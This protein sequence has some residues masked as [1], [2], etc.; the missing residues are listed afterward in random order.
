MTFRCT[1]VQT[2]TESYR[3]Q[4]TQESLFTTPK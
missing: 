3:F 4:T 2:G 1:L